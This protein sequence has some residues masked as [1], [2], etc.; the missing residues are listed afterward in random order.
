[1]NRART[2]LRLSAKPPRSLDTEINDRDV[3]NVGVRVLERQRQCVEVVELPST[4]PAIKRL[5]RRGKHSQIEGLGHELLD[6]QGTWLWG[7]RTLQ[8]HAELR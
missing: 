5:D 3:Q 4:V 2:R 8:S 1:M 7:A 6:V